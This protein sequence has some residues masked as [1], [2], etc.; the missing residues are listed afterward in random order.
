MTSIDY[1]SIVRHYEACLAK[2]GDTHKGVDWPNSLDAETR[3][4]VMIEVLGGNRDNA[5]ILDFGCGASHL[6]G[7]IKDKEYENIAYTGLDISSAF[8]EL[9]KQKYP[10]N[11]YVCL[12][13]LESSSALG[14]YDYIVM[15]GVFT[16]KRDLS[17]DEMLTYF[18]R[19]LLTVYP[20]AGLGMAFNVMSKHVD[21]ER[22]DLFH[23]PLDILMEFLTS[24]IS[25]HIVIRQDYGLFEYTVY[26]YKDTPNG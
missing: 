23:L 18:Q 15:N 22:P 2:H 20:H 16:E 7:Y 10:E 14:Q 26:V 1:R 12:D 3:Y 17:F 5:S 11:N 13:V 4:Q 25:R 6:Y 9:S 21:W 19:M 8:C 24:Q